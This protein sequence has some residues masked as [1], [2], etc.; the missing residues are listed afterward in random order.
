[1]RTL[2]SGICLLIT[3][4]TFAQ[5]Q[6][7]SS[8]YID[9][10]KIAD[11]TFSNR[12]NEIENFVR[13]QIA[14]KENGQEAPNIIT[15]PVVVH[16][17]Y[18][19]SAQN[20]SDEQINSQIDALNRDFRRRNAD[21]VNTPDRFKPFA[22]D[23]Q[24]QFQLATADPKGRA[25]NGIIRKAT[26]VYHW[27]TDDKIK[28]SSQGG[29]DAW[30]THYYLNIWVGDLA[31][32]LGYS[33]IPGAVAEKD[34]VVINYTTFGTINVGGSYN[35]GR[36]AT[37][38]VGHWLGLKHVWGDYYCGDDLVDDTPKQG[39]FTS[40]CP[41]TFRSSCSNGKMGDMYMNYMD[42]TDD[43][44]MN[45][46]TEGQKQRM[47]SLLKSG[48]PRNLLISSKGLNK[49]WVTES[50][51]DSQAVNTAFRFYP[52]PTNGEMVLNF[53]YNADWIGKVISIVNI[54]GVVVSKLQVSSKT[55]KINLLQLK[56]GMYFILA[57]NSGQK[58]REKFI[59]L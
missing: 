6:C 40:G 23:V 1:M 20:I 53:D 7:A 9:Q 32:L 57:E 26:N 38:E 4:I 19:T 44:C 5:R 13:R 46:F 10:Q 41:N 29:D 11:P 28:F 16:V 27:S 42:F 48:G 24:I 36:T 12:I 2:L 58:L 35:L 39:N 15:I 33:S 45:L 18:K 52:N 3:T 14:A 8:T 30:D 47:L 51:V 56:P 55:Q 37:H 43:A 22:A 21:T 34:G 25:T 31:G 49:P 54:N 50:P 59:K 17:I